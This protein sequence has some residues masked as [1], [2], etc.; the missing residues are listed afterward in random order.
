MKYDE[1]DYLPQMINDEMPHDVKEE[2]L[3]GDTYNKEL[4]KK[5]QSKEAKKYQH[6]WVEVDDKVYNK[7]A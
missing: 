2:D 3:V 1:E 7:G 6:Q 4:V 5:L